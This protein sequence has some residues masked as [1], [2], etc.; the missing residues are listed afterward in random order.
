MPTRIIGFDVARALAVFGMVFVNFRLACEAETGN[1]LLLVLI[2]S[3]EGR[4]SALFVVLAGIGLA[5]L[6]QASERKGSPHAGRQSKIKLAR[7]AVLLI[8][9][10]L[11]YTPI[12]PA[13]ILHFY[14]FY[15]LAAIPLLFANNRQLWFAIIGVNVAFCLLFLFLDYNSGWNF[16]TLHYKDFW[17]APGM[18]RHIFFNG[19]HPVLPWL[20]FLLLGLWLGKQP[21]QDRAFRLRIGGIALLFWLGNELISRLHIETLPAEACSE[22]LLAVFGPTAMPPIPPYI[23]AAGS[24]AVVLVCLCIELCL[25]WPK[26]KLLLALATT[27]RMSLSLYVAHVLLGMAVLEAMGLLP[28]ANIE[29]ATLAALLFCAGAIIA[30]HHWAN[31]FGT[32]PLEKVFKKL[33][34]S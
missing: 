15:F 33:A 24:L 10:G 13:D 29:T 6:R 30:C 14:G 27:G 7:R 18:I 16:E 5:I 22:D 2:S 12:W 8:I 19:F 17:S 26:A 9:L 21:L 31:R 3:M 25:R 23:L 32:G 4:A 20:S 1:A 11:A 28:G 34:G